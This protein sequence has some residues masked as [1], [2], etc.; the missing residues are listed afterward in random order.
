MPLTRH[1]DA[2]PGE[3]KVYARQNVTIPPRTGKSVPI[4]VPD[5]TSWQTLPGNGCLELG[6]RWKQM[7][8][9]TGP[10][11]YL[12]TDQKGYATMPLHNLAQ[13]PITVSAGANLG[14]YEMASIQQMQLTK[15]GVQLSESL[16]KSTRFRPVTRK[17]RKEAYLRQLVDNAKKSQPKA[18]QIDAINAT[19]QQKKAWLTETFKLKQQ[20]CLQKKEDLDAA[21]ELLLRHW[22]LF[23]HDGS[24]GHTHLLQHRIITEDV[25]PIKCRYRPINPALEPALR[26]Q[27]DEWLQHDVIEPAD[28]PWSSNLVAVKKK[29]GKIRWC[30]DWRRLN[31]VTKK[32]SWPMPTVQDTIA[33]LAGSNV[34]S[35]VDMAGAFHCVEVHPDDREKTAFATPFGTFQQK[36]L[37]FGVTNGPATYCRLVDKVLKD[38]PPT[39]ALSFIDDGVVHSDGLDTH[40]RNL[41]KTL[42]AY[43]AAGLK[44]APHKCTFFAPQITYLGHTID[45]EGIR[46][47]ASYVEAVAK[48][49]LPKFKTEAR[50]FLGITGYYRQH[51]Q[52]YAALARPWTDVIGKTADPEAEKAPLTVTPEM[53]RAF[54]E[55]KGALVTAPVLGFPYFKGPKAGQFILDTDFC[56]TQ[57]A[58]ILSQMQNG[59]EVVIA[60][61][62]KKLNKNQLN[63]PSTKG[64]LYAGLTWMDKY[65]YYLQHGPQF[66]WRT[67]NSALRSVKTMDPKGAIV[68]RWLGA[69]ATYDFEVEH[70]PGTKNT[71]ADALSRGGFPE[72][73]EP[74]GSPN[75][76]ALEAIEER[77]I[78]IRRWKEL[79]EAQREDNALAPIVQWVQTK[80]QPNKDDLRQLPLEAATY[81]GFLQDLCLEDQV[82][83]RRLPASGLRAPR[84]VP[85]L[86]ETWWGPIIK[87]AHRLGGHMGINT[88]LQRLVGAVYFPWMRTEVTDHIATCT[89]CQRKEGKQSDQRHTLCSPT[90]GYPFQRL[91]IDIVGPLSPSRS[92][93]A[94]YIL[95]CRDAFSKWP[96]AYA[97]NKTTTEVILSTLEREI[98]SRFGYPEAI[99]SDQGPQFMAKAFQAL[100]SQ[101]GIRVTN[102]TG[103][104]PKSNGQVER[105]HRD[106]NKILQA[107]TIDNGDPFAWEEQLPA[108]L[109]ALRTAVCRSTGLTP[110]KVLFGRECSV[111]ID[112]IFQAPSSNEPFASNTV[113]LRA[114]KTRIAKAHQYAREHLAEAVKRQRR[115]YH[116]ERKEFHAGSRVWLFTPRTKEGISK[117]L[118]SFW[119]GP[120]VVC[121]KPTSSETMVRITPDPKWGEGKDKTSKVVSIDRLKLY[122]GPLTLPPEADDDTTMSDDEAAEVVDA[123]DNQPLPRGAPVKRP[124]PLPVPKQTDDDSD[125]NDDGDEPPSSRTRLQQRQRSVARFSTPG[126][127]RA[128]V[129]ATPVAPNIQDRHG[130]RKAPTKRLRPRSPTPPRPRQPRV[131][132]PIVV[133]YASVQLPRLDISATWPEATTSTP[134]DGTFTVRSE[135]PPSQRNPDYTPTAT[136]PLTVNTPQELAHLVEDMSQVS[137]TGILGSSELETSYSS[138]SSEP[139]D[140]IKDPDY[141]PI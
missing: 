126:R 56:Q 26:Q 109:F 113:Q 129:A 108:A 32:D 100:E 46:P 13:H 64:E 48:W 11:V 88:T 8:L 10:D 41:D 2:G 92:S 114:I 95:T 40:L 116:H 68:E 30:V 131:T 81:V 63:Y 106:L 80:T 27:L 65:Q 61:G 50:A 94:R 33:R 1:Q 51:I 97:L 20:P 87:R 102:T 18:P 5:I 120:W 37:G 75:I 107:L 115:Q 15:E 91:H 85:C 124:M 72:P 66:K 35:G 39:E 76:D 78:R 86:P 14:S 117:K 119:T 127:L 7:G 25:P 49:P 111:P 99:H 28:S 29:G 60:Y 34:F 58:G 3:N 136:S 55:L 133:P 96:E 103:Y 110:Y 130:T 9:H 140:P 134:V 21:T 79:A 71:N 89:T 83:C 19:T 31:E 122:K 53:E 24:Y 93:G 54:K 112:S 12:A 42:R 17:E 139:D 57:T 105:M 47:V 98:F 135:R 123:P 6:T 69:L 121:A 104:N 16:R 67:D 44:L 141:N 128:I 59:T 62:S 73:A 52:D 101:L 118:T 90:M 36:R 82:L 23:S 45:Q 43:A 84:T 70:R 132:P 138:V 77:P 74:E 125:S 137:S 38:I 4:V 22:D